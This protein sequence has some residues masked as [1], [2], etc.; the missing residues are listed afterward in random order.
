MIGP[1]I[2]TFYIHTYLGS[3]VDKKSSYDADLTVSAIL[4]YFLIFIFIK[5]KNLSKKCILFGTICPYSGAGLKNGI[6]EIINDELSD[7]I[8][9]PI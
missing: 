3:T 4:Q 8:Y 7:I 2:V 1:E 5:L 6:Y 9:R